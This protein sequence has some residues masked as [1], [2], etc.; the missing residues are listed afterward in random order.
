MFNFL[1]VQTLPENMGYP[2]GGSRAD[3]KYFFLQIHYDN[4]D[5][6][7]SRIFF[8]FLLFEYDVQAKNKFKDVTDYSGIRLYVTKNYRPTEFGILT[9]SFLI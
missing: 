6:D 8:S 4:S 3:F 2:L 9:V 7:P 5:N 1:K